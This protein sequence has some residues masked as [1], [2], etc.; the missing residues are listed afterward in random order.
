MDRIISEIW[1]GQNRSAVPGVFSDPITLI[2]VYFGIAYLQ[3]AS[4]LCVVTGIYVYLWVVTYTCNLQVEHIVKNLFDLWRGMSYIKGM[5]KFIKLG[6]V[7]LLAES[8]ESVE[9]TEDKC[10]LHLFSGRSLQCN[11]TI[12]Q[13]YDL[14]RELQNASLFSR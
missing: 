14:I 5:D 3:F 7:I 2:C 12:D 9:R 13:V 6:D 10:R 8:I 4:L 11:L 1:M